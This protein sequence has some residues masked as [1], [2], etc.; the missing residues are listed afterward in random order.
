MREQIDCGVC[1]VCEAD[2]EIQGTFCLIF[3]D[4]PTYAVILDGAWP[5]DAPYATIH[6]LASAGKR[7]WV[8]RFCIDWC[9]RQAGTLRADTHADNHV[10]QHLLESA[11]FVHCGTIY[12][13]DG[14]PR[15]A[16]WRGGT[17]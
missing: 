10:M 12:T 2:G 9:G 14:T 17:Q 15:M 1:Y 7:P 8:G 5:D 6:R 13:D 4:D 3:G 16:Y 11:G